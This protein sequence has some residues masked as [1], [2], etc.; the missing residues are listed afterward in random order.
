MVLIVESNISNKVEDKFF[1]RHSNLEKSPLP[2][3][4]KDGKDYLN[5]ISSPSIDF[6]KKSVTNYA[7]VDFKLYY[8]LIFRAIQALVQQPEVADNFVHKGVVK[9]S[10]NTESK[11]RIYGKLYECDWWLKTEKLLPPMNN[12]LSVILYSDATIFDGIGKTSGHPVFLTLGN[13]SNQI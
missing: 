10:Q 11:T 4:T 9:V 8:H 2:K 6:K 13:L 7:G 12:L 5:Q 1:N 3:S